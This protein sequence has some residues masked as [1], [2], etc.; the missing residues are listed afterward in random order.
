MES[1]DDAHTH[2]K[3][4][5]FNNNN[6][7]T[8][9]IT[10]KQ[11]ENEVNFQNNNAMKF[12]FPTTM[13]FLV[14]ALFLADSTSAQENQCNADK[15]CKAPSDPFCFSSCLDGGCAVACYGG[16]ADNGGGLESP[17]NGG[18]VNN[19]GTSV[20]VQSS[21]CTFDKD[22]KAPSDPFCFSTC[23]DGG[24]SVACH[25]GGGGGNTP[26]NGGNKSSPD[27]T[28]KSSK[29]CS[30]GSYCAAGKCTTA[31]KCHRAVDCS[32]PDNIFVSKKCNGFFRC[33][34]GRC[35]KKCTSTT[36]PVRKP[37]AKCDGVDPCDAKNCNKDFVACVPSTCGGCHGFFFDAAGKQ[38]CRAQ[39]RGVKTRCSKTSDCA[40]DQFCTRGI[41]LAKGTCIKRQDCMKPDNVVADARCSSGQKIAKNKRRKRS[42]SVVCKKNQ[43][44]KKC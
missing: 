1:V 35:A 37:P 9:P 28:C 44:Q 5:K 42:G 34:Q 19:S 31:G 27:D 2:M 41:C 22:C 39:N 30:V 43:C 26:S 12:L 13:A 23:I 10:S 3:L 40:D 7:I 32:N 24:C 8:K 4:V 14:T 21:Q 11:I 18:G 15:D 29:D 6:N 16:P 17:G 20:S 25:G 33:V 36:C 38:V